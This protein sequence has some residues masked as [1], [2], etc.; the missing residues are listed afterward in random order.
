[1]GSTIVSVVVV[2]L[3]A[4][5]TCVLAKCI[6]S[7][8]IG[9]MMLALKVL[10]CLTPVSPGASLSLCSGIVRKVCSV[11]IAAPYM[12]IPTTFFVATLVPVVQ[13][14][15]QVNDD[16]LVGSDI[17]RKDVLGCHSVEIF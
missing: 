15:C 16:K 11:H 3:L 1:M 8:V 14:D 12:H 2:I 17:Y 5:T 13:L 6:V 10:A 7:K 4:L 9:N